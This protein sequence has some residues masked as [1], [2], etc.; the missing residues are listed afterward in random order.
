MIHEL[1][2]TE[3]IL[4]LSFKL[5]LNLLDSQLIFYDVHV[6]QVIGFR[7]NYLEEFEFDSWVEQLFIILYLR[8]VRGTLFSTLS[9]I[10]TLLLNEINVCPT[11]LSGT[12]WSTLPKFLFPGKE[13]IRKTM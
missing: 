2:L 4:E 9:L 1:S 7:L 6:N 11:I 13:R 12:F 5:S 8:N 10:L 3:L